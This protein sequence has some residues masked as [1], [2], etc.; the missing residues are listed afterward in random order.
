VA[1]VPVA[2]GA[3]PEELAVP[4]LVRQQVDVPEA[5]VQAAAA[6]AVQEEL[7]HRAVVAARRRRRRR[8]RGPGAPFGLWA[9]SFVSVFTGGTLFALPCVRKE[10]AYGFGFA[11]IMK[12]LAY[13]PFL[14]L[15]HGGEEFAQWFGLSF[16]G[17]RFFVLIFIPFI[18]S[19]FSALFFYLHLGGALLSLSMFFIF[20]CI[21]VFFFVPWGEIWWLNRA[22]RTFV[23]MIG[24]A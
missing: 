13:F 18:F 6:A 22:S 21:Y 15:S 4:G 11:G 10:P 20:V 19:R 5:A 16:L 17:L 24:G 9:R 3:P 8:R 2:A 12:K 14:A 7:A 23:I 1:P